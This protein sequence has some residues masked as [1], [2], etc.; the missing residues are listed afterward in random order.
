MENKQEGSVVYRLMYFCDWKVIFGI[1]F[2]REE[3]NTRARALNLTKLTETKNSNSP[4]SA[5]K[6]RFD[7]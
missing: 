2:L 7:K 1:T 5:R 3:V 6:K 4:L